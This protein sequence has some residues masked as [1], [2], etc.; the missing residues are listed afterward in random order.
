VGD[1]VF[2][3][4]KSYTCRVQTQTLSHE[5]S[6]QY[7]QTN[8][9]PYTNAFPDDAQ[10]GLQQWG[11]G[12]PYII[13]AGTDILNQSIWADTDNRDQQMVMYL[14]DITLYHLHSR[15]APRNIPQLR[16]D[17]YDAAIEWLKMCAKGDVSPGL[18]VLQPRQG[19]RVRYGSQIR[20][21]N[22]Y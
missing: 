21:I 1:R 22:S 11:T 10:F 8:N 3:K 13:D 17:R 6:L 12:E 7:Y 15:I 9:V 20:N 16:M 4:N 18:P 2:W 14:V 5:L 19:S